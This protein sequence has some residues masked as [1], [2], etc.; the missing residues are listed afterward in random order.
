MYKSVYVHI[1]KHVWYTGTV[2]I[3]D[4]ATRQKINVSLLW[5]ALIGDH[6]LDC[7]TQRRVYGNL[8]RQRLR[9]VADREGS[10]LPY[11]ESYD[12]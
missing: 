2:R 12:W 10:L 4:D 6:T 3:L 11:I 9:H 7:M 8:L 5:C 1:V